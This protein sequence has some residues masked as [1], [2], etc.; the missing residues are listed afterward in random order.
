[1]II[2]SEVFPVQEKHNKCNLLS[3]MFFMM[4]VEN[5]FDKTVLEVVTVLIACKRLCYLNYCE[6]D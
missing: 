5:Y 4:S 2:T 1:M 6:A 3:Q